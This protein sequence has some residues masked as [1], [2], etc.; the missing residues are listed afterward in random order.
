MPMLAAGPLVP[1]QYVGDAW[2]NWQG[3]DHPS[4]PFLPA[5]TWLTF[6]LLLLGFY[7]ISAIL[8]SIRVIRGFD[9]WLDRPPLSRET[10]PHPEPKLSLAETRA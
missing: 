4:D 1:P 5:T 7:A 10:R 3:L 6:T 9:R 8:L 2:W